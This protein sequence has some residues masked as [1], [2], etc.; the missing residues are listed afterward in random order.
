MTNE[1]HEVEELDTDDGVTLRVVPLETGDFRV[2]SAVDGDLVYDE[3]V[4]A[5]A[6]ASATF[7]A[8]RAAVES[9]GG[10]AR[11]RV[12]NLSVANLVGL[13]GG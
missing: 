4:R 6:V 3:T 7:A 1:A 10:D 2:W 5:A 12:G 8:V 13:L 9:L 11:E